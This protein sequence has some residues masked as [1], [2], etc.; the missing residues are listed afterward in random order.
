MRSQTAPS[1]MLDD[2]HANLTPRP[3]SS[4][5]PSRPQ[6]GRPTSAR[7]QSGRHSRS[8]PNDA[9]RAAGD[10]HPLTLNTSQEGGQRSI[11]VITPPPSAIE[12]IAVELPSSSGPQ[13]TTQ[14]TT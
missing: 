13:D 12:E 2:P 5:H 8:P 9:T 4:R 11:T 3:S 10:G 7:P 1:A 14:N 6:S